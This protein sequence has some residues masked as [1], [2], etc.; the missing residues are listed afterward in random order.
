MEAATSCG[1]N[2]VCVSFFPLHGTIIRVQGYLGKFTGSEACVC[3]CW[4][5]VALRTTGGGKARM[6]VDGK[7]CGSSLT[8]YVRG[9]TVPG[10]VWCY[11]VEM[12]AQ[13]CQ[14]F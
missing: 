6:A 12:W 9:V 1:E 10:L 4:F 8:P 14:T 7:D 13:Y 3:S 2:K 5:T 11:P